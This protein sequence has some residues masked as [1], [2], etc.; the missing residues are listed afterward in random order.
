MRRYRLEIRGVIHIGAHVGQEQAQY[1]SCGITRQVWIEPQ[2]DIFKRLIEAVSPGDHP[3][4]RVRCFNVACGSEAGIAQLH[5]LDGNDGMSNSLLEH[6]GHL[7]RWPQFK[8]AGTVDVPVVRLDDLLREE[9]IAARDHNLLVLDVQGYE[10]A[11]LQGAARTLGEVDYLITEVAAV[12][13]FK[14]GALVDELDRFLDNRGFVRVETKW[15][16]GCAGDA[17]YVRRSKLTPLMRLRLAVIG[18]KHA[19]PPMRGG[20]LILKAEGTCQ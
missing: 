19:R 18:S 8:P 12:E 9:R 6:K 2:S 3:A 14:G 13:L 17:L 16:A 10:L 15:S 20:E 4:G 5:R 11:C 1:A 7:E